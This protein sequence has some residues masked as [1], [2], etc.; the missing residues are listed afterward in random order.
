MQKNLVLVSTLSLSLASFLLIWYSNLLGFPHIIFLAPL[1]VTLPAFFVP[2]MYV[3]VARIVLPICYG[4][5]AVG[6]FSIGYGVITGSDFYTAGNFGIR[7]QAV[8]PFKA[9]D[10]FFNALTVLFSIMA[11]FLL[12]KGLTDFDK[13]KETLNQEAETIWAIVFLTSYL[14]ESEELDDSAENRANIVATD[15]ICDAFH[16]YLTK[17]THV[18]EADNREIGYQVLK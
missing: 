13:L 7:T 10:S 12:W 1:V 3:P 14:R 11:A 9:E 4:L 2:G 17:A 5:F 18:T 16:D 8:I 15:K 6:L